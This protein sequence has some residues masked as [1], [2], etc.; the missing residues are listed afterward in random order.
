L[1]ISG[2]PAGLR[3]EARQTEGAP[4]RKWI[5]VFLLDMEMRDTI[6]TSYANGY[7]EIFRQ[8]LTDAIVTAIA[9][10][11][12]VID[13]NV[14]CMRT[15]ETRDALVDCLI[16]VMSLTPYHDTPSRLRE[17]AES[18]AKKIRRDVARIRAEPCPEAERFFGFRKEGRA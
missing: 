7:G 6:R 10:A 5:G 8:R 14:M 16:T 13:A 4:I 3:I 2:L 1:D 17:D 12:M 15:G 18:L 9:E 11:S